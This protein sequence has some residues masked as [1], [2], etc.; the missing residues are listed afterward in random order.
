VKAR[1]LAACALAIVACERADPCF[2]AM[3]RKSV[4]PSGRRVATTYPGGCPDVFFATQ[5]TVEFRGSGGGG[6]FAVRDSVADIRTRWRSEDTLEIS[7]PA[8]VTIDK[9]ETVL[10]HKAARVYMVYRPRPTS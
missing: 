5:V 9:R 3:Q 7:Y 2:A 4:S 8:N 1:L 10:R 6:V